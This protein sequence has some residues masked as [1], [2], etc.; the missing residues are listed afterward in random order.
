[1]AKETKK[2]TKAIKKVMSVAA[3]F[4]RPEIQD[5]GNERAALGLAV[6]L[7]KYEM[8]NELLKPNT[9]LY[10]RVKSR[11]GGAAKVDEF[12][13]PTKKLK[14]HARDN[15]QVDGKQI[16]ARKALDAK[17]VTPMKAVK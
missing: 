15:G 2:E 3:H 5:K 13:N 16:E 17:D 11:L 8:K 4:D 7:A 1:M 6:E 10:K 9:Q 14:S 12:L